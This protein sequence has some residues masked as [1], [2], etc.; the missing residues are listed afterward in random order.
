MSTYDDR[1]EAAAA[2]GEAAVRQSQ[3]P[4]QKPAAALPILARPTFTR[5]YEIK[6][7]LDADLRE[8]AQAA[9]SEH[10]RLDANATEGDGYFVHSIYFDT[11]DLRF[12]RE[13]FEGELVRVKP[14]IRSYR[15][16][17]DGPPTATF[18]EFKGRQDRIVNKR[19]CPID[20][21]LAEILLTQT[22]VQPNGWSSRHLVLGEFQYMSHRFHL[23]PAVSV[24]YHRTAY[25]GANWPG[26]R[27]TFDRLVMCSPSISLNASSGNFMQTI[28]FGKTVMELKYNDKVPQILLRQ[29]HALGLQQRT[30][31]KY[32]ASMVRCS[33]RLNGSS[34][35]H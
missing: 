32:A 29:I 18:L 33:R 10:L 27:I 17:M 3:P 30:F 13:K 2:R 23:V 25:F 5:R 20:G 35:E 12:L 31:S 16:H 6:Y 15:A 11:P 26:L 1:G 24:L 34:E 4:A 28:P 9:L 21:P 8:K 14:R 19:R 22:P 7:L